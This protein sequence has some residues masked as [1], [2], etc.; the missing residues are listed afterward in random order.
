MEIMLRSAFGPHP[1]RELA[2]AIALSRS[3]PSLP[4]Q[5]ASKVVTGEFS[6]QCVASQSFRHASVLS[7]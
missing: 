2:Y 7:T 3:R 1:T 6:Y 5:M 4:Y